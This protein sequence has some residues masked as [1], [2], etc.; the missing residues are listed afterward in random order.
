[1]KKQ[2]WELWIENNKLLED[3]F[4]RFIE[5]KTIRKGSTE[6][7]TL[8]HLKKA[9]RNL[10]FSR[11]VIDEF[12]EFYEWSITAY[13]YAIYHAALSLCAKKGYTTKKHQATLLLLIKFYYPHHITKEELKTISQTSSLNENDIKDF[14]KLKDYREDATYSISIN[15]E[16]EITEEIA[17]KATD[18]INKAE[19]I[20]KK[21]L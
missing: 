14:A 20:Q 19:E 3:D 21:G 16:K 10:H 1:M 8:G 12:K 9:K 4:K 5:N 13:Y 11:R 2:R 17:N 18:F 7:E 15:Y 6:L